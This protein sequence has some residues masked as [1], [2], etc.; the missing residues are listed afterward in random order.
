MFAGAA[1]FLASGPERSGD[2]HTIPEGIVTVLSAQRDATVPPDAVAAFRQSLAGPA[3][4]PV[5]EAY[6]DARHIWNATIGRRPI[7]IARCTTVA[8]V[9]RSNTCGGQHDLLVSVRG[10]G[11]NIRRAGALRRWPDDRSLVDERTSPWT[12]RL[13]RC[14]C[15]GSERHEGVHL[16][17]RPRGERSDVGHARSRTRPDA[18]G[19]CEHALGISCRWHSSPRVRGPILKG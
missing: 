18:T 9:Q 6:E 4:E 17:D 19:T 8:D 3:L 14:E 12:P 16:V 5:G 1:R 7:L 10:G 2:R 15:G 13:R 11:H